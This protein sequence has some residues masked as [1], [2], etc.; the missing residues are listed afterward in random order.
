GAPKPAPDMYLRACELL[1]TDPA[2]TLAFEDSMTGLRSARAA[3]LRVVGV[4][5]LRDGEFPADL[6]VDSLQDAGLLAWMTGWA[7]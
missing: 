5:T 2:D 4:P 1:G 6:V 3:G 7:R